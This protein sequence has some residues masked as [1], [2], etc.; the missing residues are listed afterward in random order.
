[1]G[2]PHTELLSCVLQLHARL[3]DNRGP[4]W[5]APHLCD[6]SQMFPAVG[7]TQHPMKT[8]MT[9][10]KHAELCPCTS[11]RALCLLLSLEKSHPSATKNLPRA[12]LTDDSPTKV[13][14]HTPRLTSLFSTPTPFFPVPESPS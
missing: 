13:G 11:L 4:P 6:I 1:M 3:L 10:S 9:R 12:G 2:H 14:E 7:G 5:A 8:S